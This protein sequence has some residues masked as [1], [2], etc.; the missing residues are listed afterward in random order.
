MR[1]FVLY[2]GTR[3]REVREKMIFVGGREEGREK[4]TRMAAICS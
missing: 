4:M 2:G 3:G 1:R